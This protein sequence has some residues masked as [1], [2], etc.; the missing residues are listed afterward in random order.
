M[1]AGTS[2]ALVSN[3]G[4]TSVTITGTVAQI[5]AL[6]NTNGTSA[7]SYI[8]NSDAP[9]AST[10]LTLQVNDNGN[11]GSGGALSNSTTAAINITAVNDAPGL[12][13]IAAPTATAEAINA[14]QQDIA[15]IHGTLSV[16]DPD[17]GNTLTAL[18]VGGPVVQLN[19]QPFTLPS[20]AV[21]SGLSQSYIKNLVTGDGSLVAGTATGSLVRMRQQEMRFSRPTVRRSSS[22]WSRQILS[23]TTPTARGTLSSR[24]WRPA[25]SRGFDQRRAATGRRSGAAAV[26]ARLVARR[27]QGCLRVNAEQ[28]RCGRH[29]RRRR[30]L[31]PR[32]RQ[33]YRAAD[34]SDEDRRRSGYRQGQ[35]ASDRGVPGIFS[36]RHEGPVPFRCRQS[37]C[38]RQQQ[39]CRYLHQGSGDGRRHARLDR[40]QWQRRWERAG[41]LQCRFL[42]T[43]RRSSFPPRPRL[44][45]V[46]TSASTFS[47]KT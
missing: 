14:F 27:H 47:S 29:E 4:T 33:Q 24:I 35:R 43:A 45:Q 42:P 31:C 32:S 8:N 9:P 1:T 41:Q 16:S 15:A 37:G 11:T 38:E 3:S 28:S 18:I 39:R 5:N 12:A 17:I 34:H 10:I 7:V 44:R 46:Q 40:Q 13:A 20:G 6:L 19:G 30:S 2:G 26:R 21:I 23:R 25:P 22:H 36:G